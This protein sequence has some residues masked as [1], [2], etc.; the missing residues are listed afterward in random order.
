MAEEHAQKRPK[1][2]PKCTKSGF[3]IRLH[4]VSPFIVRHWHAPKAL[5]RTKS[6]KIN[7]LG[8]ETAQWGGVLPGKE[9]GVAE[10]VPCCRGQISIDRGLHAQVA[11]GN[12][13][14]LCGSSL[15]NS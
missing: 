5:V 1:N 8:L 15:S 11:I 14:A 3:H 7:S 12:L 2:A 4:A 10:F 9:V 6:I 13:R